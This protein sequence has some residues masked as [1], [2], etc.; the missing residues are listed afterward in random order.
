MPRMLSFTAA[1]GKV[2][3]NEPT[4]IPAS[5][6]QR[7]YPCTPSLPR[8]EDGTRTFISTRDE[9]HGA[10]ESYDEIVARLNAK[11]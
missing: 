7:V 6:V 1:V 9:L 4:S 11:E 3:T 5:A 2:A 8:Y 10:T